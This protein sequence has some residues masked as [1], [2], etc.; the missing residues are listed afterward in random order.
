METKNGIQTYAEIKE[1]IG[2]NRAHL[3]LGNGFSI[4]CDPIFHY[5]RLFD[6]A[7]KAG[8][9]DRAKLVFERIGT[10]NFEAVMRL[11]DDTYWVAKAY[12]LLQDE[13]SEILDDLNIIQKTL[14]EAVAYSHLEH[15]GKVPDS[16]K[17]SALSFMSQYH[18]IFTTNYDLL[19]YWV[20]MSADV[21]CR[22]WDG[23]RSDEEDDGCPYV[24]FSERLGSQKGLFYLHGALHLYISQGE[25]RKQ[26]WI[27]TG[28]HLTQ[29][30]REG[31]KEKNYP[32]FVAEGTAESKME[33][34][35]RC[36]YL[37]YCFDKFARIECPLVVFG[38]SLG[39]SDR[40]ITQAITNNPK[41]S[42]IAVG[43]HGDFQSAANKSIIESVEKMKLGRETLQARRPKAKS[44]D[45][46]YYDSES[47][48]VWG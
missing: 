2:G 31:L 6:A 16:K 1:E 36:G 7:V 19:A 39:D 10:S 41:L 37:W 32:L 11:L 17:E 20:N 3:L 9:S 13:S 44:L 46:Y 25:L 48:K 5:N 4:A 8:L 18:N 28:K 43:L 22:W 34:I 27:R 15:T 45:V 40:H 26:T 23:F 33:Q 29:L 24:V 12:K 21:S 35:Q 38:H 14:V 47:A 30:I 42:Q